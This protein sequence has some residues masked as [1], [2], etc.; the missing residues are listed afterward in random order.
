MPMPPV[1]LAILTLVLGASA[2]AESGDQIHGAD[3]NMYSA[4]QLADFEHMRLHITFSE[5]DLR[6]RRAQGRVEYDLKARG[7]T[8]TVLRLD[9]TD[10][11]ILDVQVDG[12]PVTW[13]Y[14]DAVLLVP[15]PEPLLRGQATTVA[16]RYRIDDPPE[17]LY[18]VLPSEA[19][20]DRPTM[21]YTLSEALWARYWLPSHDWPNERW[22]SETSITVPASMTAITNGELMETRSDPGGSSKTFS[23]RNEIPT[24]PHMM[25]FVIGEL[26][27]IADDGSSPALPIYTQAGQEAAARNTFRLVRPMIEFY[28]ER[29]GVPFVFPSYTHVTVV[30]HVHGAMEQAGFS[31][32]DPIWLTTGPQGEAPE[33]WVE[34]GYTAHMITHQWF[35]GIVNYRSVSQTWLNEGFASYLDKLW[36]EQRHGAGEFGA[37]MRQVA[38]KVTRTDDRQTGLPLVHRALDHANDIFTMGGGKIYGKGAWLLHMLRQRL[39]DD[40]FFE[41]VRRYLE[42]NRW[43]GVETQDLRRTLEEVSGLDLEQF[44]QQWVYQGGVPLLNVA[45]S[46]DI[47]A[48]QATVVVT[49]TQAIDNTR[50]AFNTPLELLVRVAGVDTTIAVQLTEAHHEFTWRFAQEPDFICIDPRGA[51]L[52]GLQLEAP[53]AQLIAQAHAAPTAVARLD[54]IAALG[55]IDHVDAEQALIEIVANEQEE[56]A[57]RQRAVPVL[58]ARQTPLALAALQARLNDTTPLVRMAVVRGIG[59]FIGSPVAHET[60]LGKV[61]VRDVRVAGALAYALGRM[62]GSAALHDRSSQRLRQMIS[63]DARLHVRR[64]ALQS[65]DGEHRPVLYDAVRKA[66]RRQGDRLR[67]LAIRRLGTFGRLAARRDDVRQQLLP[68]LNGADRTLQEAAVV[69]L[70]LSWDVRALADLRRIAG[71]ARG[72]ATRSAAEQAIQTIQD[73]P[74]PAAQEDV[75]D[76]LRSLEQR[77]GELEE[78]L[79]TLE[80][81]DPE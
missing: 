25:G 55:E 72:S 12:D 8:L 71:S 59:S 26:V 22:T 35:G 7:Q 67:P 11:T 46:W 42:E 68:W 39:G 77:Y 66:T 34:R 44:F 70:G 51:L 37:L 1:M 53:R 81:G 4:D 43:Q 52:K 76:L 14:D 29:L 64:A 24:D 78:R 61:D 18:F 65:I 20:P 79:E 38:H 16:V 30:E 21:V 9:A 15:L 49:Q 60:L 2:F 17:G 10:M 74:R 6:A 13:S 5:E 73:A 80:M 48:A 62:Q 75:V 19:E 36:V 54:A 27:E 45:S 28:S 41:G 69:A 3:V 58:A 57:V 31:F 56:V 32:V 40:L 63:A 23:W 33:D 47:E 50:P